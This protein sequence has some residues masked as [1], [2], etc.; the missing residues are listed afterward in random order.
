MVCFLLIC[1]NN[2][3]I[4]NGGQTFCGR[5]VLRGV[6]SLM[7]NRVPVVITLSMNHVTAQA[8]VWRYYKQV[9]T[10]T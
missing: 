4:G 6:Y 9:S 5:W 7:L 8:G 2:N 10:V 3:S 1:I